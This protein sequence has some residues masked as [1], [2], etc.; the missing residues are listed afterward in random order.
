VKQPKRKKTI[1]PRKPGPHE[2]LHSLHP[3]SFEQALGIALLA[4]PIKSNGPPKKQKTKK[5]KD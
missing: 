3:L 1:Y 4:K 5:S 2:Q